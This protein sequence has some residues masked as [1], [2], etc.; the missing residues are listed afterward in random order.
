MSVGLIMKAHTCQL[1]VGALK[2]K[3]EDFLLICPNFLEN[4]LYPIVDEG[5]KLY[6][7][8]LANHIRNI[9]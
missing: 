3:K 9:G 4:P 1:M 8:S 5:E 2:P 6:D 7:A